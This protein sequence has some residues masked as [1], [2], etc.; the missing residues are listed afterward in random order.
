MRKLR[1]VTIIIVLILFGFSTGLSGDFYVIPVKNKEATLA[2]C[3][4]WCLDTF[5]GNA[6][7]VGGCNCGCEAMLNMSNGE[8]P[9]HPGC[10]L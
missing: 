1:M 3:K 9:P 8:D 10:S 4:Q 6:N 7:Q 2:D 5:G